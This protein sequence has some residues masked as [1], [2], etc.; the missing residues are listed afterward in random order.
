MSK[1]T[2]LEMTQDILD[3][4][5]SDEINSI[6]DTVESRQ[7]VTIIKNCYLDMVS[8]EGI[9]EVYS[10]FNLTSSGDP[11]KPVVMYKPVN[12]VDIGW[13]KYNKEET[14]TQSPLFLEVKYMPIEEYIVYV[15]QFSSLNPD[16]A[17][18]TLT[19]NGSTIPFQYKT[20]EHPKYYTSFDDNTLVFDGYHSDYDTTLQATKTIVYG[21]LS[22][23]FTLTDT[24]VPALDERL[25][26]LLYNEAKSLA[27]A[28]L[29][30]AVNQKAEQ[31]A[32]RGLVTLQKSKRDIPTKKRPLDALPNYARR[33]W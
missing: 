28:E 19:L 31:A 10:L 5:D 16:T 21:Q 14:G 25:F 15:N 22:S 30:Q 17:V 2:L 8:R 11:T 32:K 7:V 1:R 13:I 4:L 33:I 9:P 20:K 26:S 6:S 3:S 12:T 18:L 29:K 24:F 23:V 27:W